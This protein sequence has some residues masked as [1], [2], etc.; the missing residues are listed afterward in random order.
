MKKRALTKQDIGCCGA[1]CGTCKP[2]ATGN[3]RGCKIGY[4]DGTRD[5]K[6]AK[7]RIK[8]CCIGKG[9]TTCADCGNRGICEIIGDWHG[10]KGYKY[11]KYRQAIDFIAGNGYEKFIGIARE[12]SN[13][14]GRYPAEHTPGNPG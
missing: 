8:V 13:A 10:R 2:F 3:C 9:F 5:L 4:D 7:C 14:C 12:W 1:V 6:K 11:G